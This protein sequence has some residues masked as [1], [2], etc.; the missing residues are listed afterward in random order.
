[1]NILITGATGFVGVALTRRLLS[2]GNHCRCLVRDRQKA[3]SLFGRSS[4]IEFRVGDLNDSGSLADISKNIDT[5]YHLAAAGSET[6][7]SRGFEEHIFQTNVRGT[8]NLLRECL[9]QPVRK[10]IHFSSTS[11]MGPIETLLADEN[12]KCR[13]VTPYQRSKLEGE[14]L[15]L[16]YWREYQLPAVVLRPC[17]VY[18]PGGKGRL[19]DITRLVKR[20]FFPRLG[21]TQVSIF[22]VDVRDV[23]N[24]ALLAL[25]K[26]RLGDIYI[27][28]SEQAYD[29]DLIHKLISEY[30]GLRRPSL[31]V[32][33]A[34][35]KA[36]AFL[37]EKAADVTRTRPLLRVKDIDAAVAQGSLS[38][39]KAKNLLGFHPEVDLKSGLRDTL[40]WY[41]DS[42]LI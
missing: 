13:P 36:A 5:V 37:I 22:M 14:E 18:G 33:V 6:I 27:I 31:H 17:P 11:A 1:M 3:E 26:G 29:L 15:V 9:S 10:L 16:R 7:R 41:R 28:A 4:L 35:V 32:P 12:T 39:E 38:I 23:V 34:L 20:G 25:S 21:N 8:E 19:Y 30:L 40:R 2:Q 24:A 42:G